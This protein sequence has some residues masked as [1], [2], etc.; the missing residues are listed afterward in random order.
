M[1]QQ[2]DTPDREAVFE[3]RAPIGKSV[4]RTRSRRLVGGRG[5]YPDDIRLPR[6]LHAAFFRSPH[7]HARIVRIDTAAALERS[8]V[9]H[10][11][12]GADI[13][14]VCTPW[15]GVAAHLPAL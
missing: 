1:R 4:E 5:R 8:G 3:V 14:K 6:M 10:V 11:F 12:T 9:H 7:A 15:S 13:A 2:K